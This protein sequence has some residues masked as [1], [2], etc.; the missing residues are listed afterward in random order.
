[1]NI[2]S[3]PFIFFHRKR[4]NPPALSQHIHCYCCSALRNAYHKISL[5]RVSDCCLQWSDFVHFQYRFT[6]KYL[7]W[8]WLEVAIIWKLVSFCACFPHAQ[9][10]A[11]FGQRGCPLAS[12]AVQCIC[13]S[14][15]PWM[16]LK[17]PPGALPHLC[18]P[19]VCSTKGA[20]VG[21]PM[22]CS[23]R[24]TGQLWPAGHGHSATLWLSYWTALATAKGQDTHNILK[25][26]MV[27]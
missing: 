1:M 5:F 13:F 8:N 23:H 6:W 10:L 22:H 24:V 14:G 4:I 16:H 18:S 7:V 15:S 9:G 25:G 21:Q 26:A 12:S 27:T 3:S 2:W 20:G 11:F 19:P 17:C